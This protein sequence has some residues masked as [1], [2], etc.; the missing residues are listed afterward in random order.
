MK[1]RFEAAAA[2]AK[3]AREEYEAAVRSPFLPHATTTHKRTRTAPRRTYTAHRAHT[4]PTHSLPRDT[5]FSE[6]LPRCARCLAGERARRH[7]GCPRQGES[8]PGACHRARR[9]VSAVPPPAGWLGC[10]GRRRA[11]RR[12]VTPPA[13][14]SLGPRPALRGAI[15]LSPPAASSLGVRTRVA[16]QRRSP[17]LRWCD[18]ASHGRG[19]LRWCESGQAARAAGATTRLPGSAMASEPGVK[20]VRGG[21]ARSGVEFE[22]CLQSLPGAGSHGARFWSSRRE[23]GARGR[24]FGVCAI[25]FSTIEGFVGEFAIGE[26]GLSN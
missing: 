24:R 25:V 10:A 12:P 11:R 18:P 16:P 1:A 6:L 7:D 17:R 2:E 19:L 21:L 13:T 3:A 22:R 15:S 23:R 4:A 8:G 14:V 20:S 5:F 9:R 26:S